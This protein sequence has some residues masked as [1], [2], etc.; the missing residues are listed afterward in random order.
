MARPNKRPEPRTAKVFLTNRSQAVRL[1]KEYQFS[2][3]EVFIRREGEE[4][5][6]A[7]RPRDWSLYLDTAPVASKEFMADVDDLPVQERRS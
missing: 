7:P 2:T 4:V 3:A 1:P 5:I 6:L